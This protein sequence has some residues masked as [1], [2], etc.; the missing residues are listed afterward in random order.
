MILFGTRHRPQT[1]TRTVSV[2]GIG[3]ITLRK[4]PRARRTTIYVRPPADITVSFPHASPEA[5]AL[6]FV[7]LKKQ[8]IIDKLNELK[9][10]PE[11]Q[12]LPDIPESGRKAAEDKLTARLR[13]L[14]EKHGFTYNRV[15][16]R[17]QKTRWGSCSPRNN[18]SLNIKLTLLPAELADYVMLH[19][20][21]HTHLHNHSPGFWK[22]LD[23]YVG[24]AKRLAAR[25]RETNLKID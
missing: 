3:D 14:A 18:I 12:S 20:L 17:N 25:L 9:K 15:T 8:W 16:I 1:E 10:R 21:V 22:E 23:K 19:E 7:A 6:E 13:Q 24:N 2:P 11:K 4:S 5:K